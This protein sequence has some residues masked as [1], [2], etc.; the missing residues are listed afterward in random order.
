MFAGDVTD[1]EQAPDN[2]DFVPMFTTAWV[3]TVVN[4]S[5]VLLSTYRLTV[6]IFTCHCQQWFSCWSRAIKLLSA[7]CWRQYAWFVDCA[8][9]SLHPMKNRKWWRSNVTLCFSHLDSYLDYSR[10]QLTRKTQVF[11]TTCITL[12]LWKPSILC[13]DKITIISWRCWWLVV[14]PVE[15][16]ISSRY[17][18]YILQLTM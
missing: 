3:V 13:D 1:L 2:R 16:L 12:A 5:R 11:V 14:V 18:N 17:V 8:D 4:W 7:V 10:V 9:E 15:Y 6:E